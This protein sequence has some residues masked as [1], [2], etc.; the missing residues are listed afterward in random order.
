MTPCVLYVV[1]SKTNVHQSRRNYHGF[2]ITVGKWRVERKWTLWLNYYCPLTVV[3]CL[4]FCD[5]LNLYLKPTVSRAIRSGHFI[6]RMLMKSGTTH[7]L[8]EN[9]S[10]NSVFLEVICNRFMLQFVVRTQLTFRCIL[11]SFRQQWRDL[12]IPVPATV[13]QPLFLE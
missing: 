8:S 9:G 2:W 3:S 13:W 1:T 11:I 12:C 6:D 10:Q 7:L 4:C 5:S